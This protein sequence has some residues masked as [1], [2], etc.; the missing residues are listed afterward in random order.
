MHI[1][2]MTEK[3]DERTSWSSHWRAAQETQAKQSIMIHSWRNRRSIA[4]DSPWLFLSLSL[5][6][7]VVLLCLFLSLTHGV[8]I[9]VEC[10]FLERENVGFAHFSTPRFQNLLRSS[11]PAGAKERTETHALVSVLLSLII[12]DAVSIRRCRSALRANSSPVSIG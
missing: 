12:D 4:V 5:K 6:L 7:L 11:L 3:R 2:R 10:F 1:K 9:F 8:P